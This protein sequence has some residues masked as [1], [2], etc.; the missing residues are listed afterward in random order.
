VYDE[1]SNFIGDMHWQG[2]WDFGEGEDLRLE[3]GG[4]EVQVCECIGKKEQDLTE[5]LD[6]RVKDR[7]DRIASKAA[8]TM[9]IQPQGQ[10]V[11]AQ[12]PRPS[13][14]L[15]RPKALNSVIGPSTGHYGR[16]IVPNVS[17]FEKR[18]QSN[19]DENMS[20]IPARQHKRAEST[21]TGGGYAQRL[22]GATLSLGS[23]KQLGTAIKYEPF[24]S[25]IQRSQT[26]S[27][28]K[29]KSEEGICGADRHNI[30]EISQ[31]DRPRRVQERKLHRY[32]SLHNYK[33]GF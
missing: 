29:S 17:P 25:S 2:D 6:K 9:S 23:Q 16:A 10:F 33:H 21:I 14:E 3:R 28:E 18:Q 32:G 24:R 13:G 4:V 27:A 26:K 8:S 31:E 19:R 12:L 15:P 1:R 30:P 7:E 22:M 5:L 20:E 11:R